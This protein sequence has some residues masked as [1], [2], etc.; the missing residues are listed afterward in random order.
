[1]KKRLTLFFVSL[2]LCVGTAL[3]QTKVSGTVLS[4]EDGQPIIGAAVKV[5]G[6]STGML[7]DV[8][9]RFSVAL[10]AGKDQLEITYL[11]FEGKTVKAKNGMRIFLKADAQLVDEVVV[12]AYGTA[13]KSSFTGSAQSVNSEALELRPV[14]SATKAL[15]GHVSGIQM[16]SSSG[17][18]GSSPSIRIRGFGSINASNDPLYV[19]D[20]IPYAGSLASI[21]PADIESMTILKDAS[22]GALYGARGANGVVMITTKKGKE[23]KANVSWRSNIGW[24]NRA[25]KRYSHVSQKEYVQLVY[26]ALRNEAYVKDGM[27]WTDAEAAGRAGLSSNLGGELY[28]PFKNYTWDTIIDPTTGQVQADAEA[29]WNE[30]WLDAVTRKNAIRHEHQFSVNGGTEKTKYALSLGYLNEDGTLKT[31]AYQRYNARVNVDTKINEWFKANV[32]LNV[33]H[34]ISNFSN[35]SGSSTS[36]V[37]YTAQFINPL[38]PVY[39]KDENGQSIYKN[40]QIEYDWGEQRENGDKRPGSMSDHS[41]L[42]MLMLD[43]AE[44]LRDVAGMRS[45]LVFGSDN[46]NMGWAKGIKL[47][48]NFGFDYDNANQMNYMNMEHGNQAAQ[49]GYLTKDNYRTQSYTFNQ[50]LTWNRGFGKHEFDV[51]AGHEFYAYKYNYLEAGRSGLMS[52]LLELRPGATLKDADSYSIDYRI[53]SWLSRFNYTFD[54]KYYLSAS[55]RADAS[56]R[57]KKG[58]RTGT[59]W[60]LGANW[61]IS[62]EKF[63]KDIK[64]I[65]NLSFKASYGEQGNDN[66]G[67]YYAWQGLSSVAYPNA[68]TVGAVLSTLENA[69]LSWEKNGNLNIGLEGSALNRRIRFSAEYYHRKTTDMLLDY[70]MAVSTGFSGYSANV[71]NMKNYGFEF[72]VSG[73]PVRTKDF[74][75]NLTWMGSTVKNEVTKLTNESPEILSGNYII[76]EGLPINTFYL[77]KSAGVDPAT[78]S[79]LY[80]IYD[81]DE[82]GNKINERITDSYNE[83]ASSRYEMGS[84]I[85]DLYGSISTDLSYKGFSLSVLTTYSIGGKILDGNY[86]SDMN[87]T[88]LNGTWNT[89]VL[90]RWQ[91]PG[92]V[93]DVPRM[94]IKEDVYITDRYLIDASY[95]AIKNITLSYTLPKNLVNK[96][97]LNGVKVYGSYDNVALFS[98][99]DGM[100]PQYSFSGGTS[101]SYAP[102][103]TLT[104]GLEVNF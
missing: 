31:T 93:T 65:D 89:N 15:E 57:F 49:G 64:W 19:V 70:P 81:T 66:V 42:G 78:G 52:G 16:T 32:G 47:A 18:P 56:S 28:N 40:G 87:L 36:N 33:A 14:S 86:Y 98:H 69:D 22:A 96:C 4:Q 104:V 80:W 103:K 84:R 90:R 1:M 88:Y 27:S 10:P 60:S 92:D 38:F 37:W 71:G 54:N 34:S 17:Q 61:R 68:N 7:T 35:Y 63:M 95:F 8:N 53:N 59:F 75:W 11:G 3:A 79:Q 102:N 20:G 55:L 12:V 58:N 85:P 25:T 9:G 41:S 94:G 91:K 77:R 21:N 50:L 99:L 72:E 51:L 44:T 76:K 74:E 97:G 26:E 82:N 46:D 6:T 13:K 39:L 2:F 62:N 67:S 45:G 5:V 100:D 43:K 83:A 73:T 29:A 48:I 30:D 101:T 24:S 23:G